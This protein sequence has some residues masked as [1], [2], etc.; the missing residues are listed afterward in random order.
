[1]ARRFTEMSKAEFAQQ[2]EELAKA[3]LEKP[4]RLRDAAA[5]DWAE[6]DDGIHRCVA[7]RRGGL[8][9]WEAVPGRPC[10][11]QRVFIRI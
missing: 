5:I 3:K 10:M 7:G 2:V 1:M 6:I 11:R 9:L 8:W 4:K